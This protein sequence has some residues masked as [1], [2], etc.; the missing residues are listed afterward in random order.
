MVITSPKQFEYGK[1]I[2]PAEWIEDFKLVAKLNSWPEDDHIDLMKLYL[3]NKEKIW[4]KKNKSELDSIDELEVELNHL[5]NKANIKDI[6]NKFDLLV[7]TLR[8]EFKEKVEENSITEW[9]KVIELITKVEDGSV[10]SPKKGDHKISKVQAKDYTTNAASKGKSVKEIA[11]N[12]VAYSDMMKRF[13]EMSVSLI[14]K[15]EQVVDQKLK[16]AS[17]SNRRVQPFVVKC[18]SCNEIGHRKYEC[19]KIKESGSS[20]GSKVDIQKNINY[21]EVIENH[22]A[23]EDDAQV[24]AIDKRKH[25]DI[26]SGATEQ[27]PTKYRTARTRGV[28]STPEETSGVAHP[29][30]EV[31][32]ESLGDENRLESNISRGKNYQLLKGT[33]K[34]FSII[35]EL[36]KVYPK[37]DALQLIEN[38]PIYSEELQSFLKKDKVME[39]N[40][41][42]VQERKTSNC[43]IMVQVF[44]QKLWAVVDTGA[45]CSV[46]TYNL[47]EGWGLDMDSKSG[48][49]L[50]T[51]DGKRHN[52][53]GRLSQV[54]LMIASFILPV[55]L[56]VMSRNDDTL[57]LGTDWLLQHKASLNLKV[58]EL[59]I[60]IE[61]VEVVTRLET[62]ADLHMEDE[63]AELYAILKQGPVGR[64]SC[65]EVELE[66][67][68]HKYNNIFV[69]DLSELT[70]TSVIEHR[71]QAARA[72]TENENEQDDVELDVFA[73]EIL[74]YEDIKQ[75]LTEKKLPDNIDVEYKERLKRRSKLYK[76]DK[77]KLMK[78]VKGCLKEVLHRGNIRQVVESIHNEGHEG[79]E[80]TWLRVSQ[81]YTSRN[82]YRE[83]KEIV[84]CCPINDDL[85]VLRNLAHKS[86][87]EAK[88]SQ[89]TR[90]NKGVT[91]HRFEVGEKVLKLVDMERS[92]LEHYWEGPYTVER[93][94][95]K[96]AY[97]ISDQE[98]NRELAHGDMLKKYHTS[99]Y[100][101]P[102]V[103]T[104][105]KTKLKRFK[106][107][108]RN[109]N[110]RA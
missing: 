101:I 73:M 8:E 34:T 25:S 104:T 95:S 91:Y 2:D 97:V 31:G 12:S 13:E 49:T 80:N 17:T 7:S 85:P 4:F 23:V 16:E 78:E 5:L 27:R 33:N 57:I 90:Y 75:Y 50:V 108:R 100:M 30:A 58:P 110:I 26:A 63:K 60:P 74:E 94:L 62:S 35:E 55:N 77:G 15:V 93:A 81:R 19:P 64:G 87:I 92:K 45:A 86:S 14:T 76:I 105:L 68:I 83:V 61:N 84:K 89:A 21:I 20:D 47:M 96:G 11:K 6:G 102:D 51:A 28:H 98:G 54:P 56:I 18:Y 39:L 106:Q 88:S 66:S 107:S 71:I 59:R 67:V 65:Q 37:I 41:I 9:D 82:I 32:D 46:V 103:T 29:T 10:V 40:E 48:L 70:Q 72:V 109:E 22:S 43:R 69:S 52:T 24:Y 36:R 53:L 79:I 1:G 44:G 38:A 99:N 3:G 42:Q